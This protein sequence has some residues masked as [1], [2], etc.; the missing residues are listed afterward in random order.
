MNVPII[1]DRNAWEDLVVSLLQAGAD[2]TYPVLVGTDDE[3]NP[4]EEAMKSLGM[5]ME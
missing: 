2:P 4:L 1:F 3:T 5:D